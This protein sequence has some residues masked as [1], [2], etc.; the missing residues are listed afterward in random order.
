MEESSEY[1]SELRIELKSYLEKKSNLSIRSFAKISGVN[2]YFLGKILSEKDYDAKSFDFHQVYLL[3]QFLYKKKS[4]RQTYDAGSPAVKD[5]LLN[6]YCGDLESKS[7]EKMPYKI[8]ESILY[9]FDYFA[10]LCFA[11]IDNMTIEIFEKSFPSTK[12]HKV[13]DLIE[14]GFIEVEDDRIWIPL[15]GEIFSPPRN[16][17]DHHIPEILKHFFSPENSGKQR[18]ISSL[19]FQGLNRESWKK[20]HSLHSDFMRQI[21]DIMNDKS[22]RGEFPIYSINVLDTFLNGK[23]TN[24]LLSRKENH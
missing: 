10:I 5:A 19:Y 9:D 14:K 6:F 22:N 20:V 7:S 12:I 3:T 15:D 8:P 13:D 2:R 11:A 1:I 17:I 23:E 16:I 4:L 24:I 18:C 21:S